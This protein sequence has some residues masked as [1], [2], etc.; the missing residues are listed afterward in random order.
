MLRSPRLRTSLILVAFVLLGGLRANATT[1]VTWNGPSDF[2]D[3]TITFA[4]FLASVLLDV[5]DTNLDDGDAQVHNHSTTVPMTA[6]LEI[7]LNGVWTNLW[8]AAVP[9][10]AAPLYLT[11]IPSANF[12]LGMVSGIR[13]LSNPDQ[14]DSYHS[15]RTNADVTKGL[16]FTFDAK[17]VASVPEPTSLLLFGTG[18]AGLAAGRL[19]QRRRQIP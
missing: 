19:K 13:L 18:I 10:S 2:N 9:L 1:I 8:T 17:G 7:L 12:S 11:T 4:P 5:T 3:A 6:D 14:F 15:L 16:Q